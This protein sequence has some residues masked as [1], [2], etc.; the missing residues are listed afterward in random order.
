MDKDVAEKV[1]ESF[2]RVSD[3]AEMSYKLVKL[4]LMVHPDAPEN[5][6]C[7]NQ[8]MRVLVN[9]DCMKYSMINPDKISKLLRHVTNA[10]LFD[11]FMLYCTP[12][13]RQLF[14]SQLTGKLSKETSPSIV[15]TEF[16]D[17]LVDKWLLEYS[18]K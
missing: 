16:M 5:E 6:E 4:Q 2:K 3:E 17:E 14:D 8:L 13:A 15:V 10:E 7:I 1:I 12:L 9:S 18:E 11:R